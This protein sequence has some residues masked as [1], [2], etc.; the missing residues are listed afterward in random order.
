M[1]LFEFEEEFEQKLRMRPFCCAKLQKERQMLQEGK[2]ARWCSQTC[3]GRTG[4]EAWRSDQDSCPISTVDST[5]DA[6][7]PLIWQ[8]EPLSGCG[9]CFRVLGRLIFHLP[10]IPRFSSLGLGIEMLVS[11]CFR[12]V[13]SEHLWHPSAIL[14]RHRPGKSDDPKNYSLVQSLCMT[15]PSVG[16]MH[17]LL[18]YLLKSHS[19]H[20]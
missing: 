5:S 10:P 11:K 7:I 13:L 15:I 17:C 3:F 8:F 9:R 16:A 12:S 2:I 6:K 20:R 4:N 1:D 18:P 19:C 14:K